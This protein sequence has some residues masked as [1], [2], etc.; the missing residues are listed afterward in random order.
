MGWVS[1]KR[2][3]RRSGETDD[4]EGWED[5]NNRIERGERRR[6]KKKKGEE[7]KERKKEKIL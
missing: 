7:K 2:R 5:G 1:R 3:G 4:N 6:R